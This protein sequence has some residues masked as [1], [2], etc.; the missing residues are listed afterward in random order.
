MV[1]ELSLMLSPVT[2]GSSGTASVFAQF[3]AQKAGKPVEFDLKS[4]QPLDSGG[5]YLRYLAKNVKMND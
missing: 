2:D 3:Q 5:L 1:D 4:V